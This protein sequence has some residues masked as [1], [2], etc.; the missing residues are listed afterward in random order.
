MI[1]IYIYIYIYK[2]PLQNCNRTYC[3]DKLIQRT[4]FCDRKYKRKRNTMST[5]PTTPDYPLTESDTQNT[6]TKHTMLT[7]GSTCTVVFNGSLASDV[8]YADSLRYAVLILD[9]GGKLIIAPTY[10]DTLEKETREKQNAVLV[11]PPPVSDLPYPSYLRSWTAADLLN[12]VCLTDYFSPCVFTTKPMP[13]GVRGIY[14]EGTRN[15]TPIQFVSANREED[16]D[17]KRFASELDAIFLRNK[18]DKASYCHAYSRQYSTLFERFRKRQ[19]LRYLEVSWGDESVKT[20]REWFPNADRIVRIDPKGNNSF[21]PNTGMV[22]IRGTGT[23]TELIERVTREHGP[24]DIIVDDGT[25]VLCD[26]KCTFEAMFP[27]LNDHGLYIVEDTNVAAAESFFCTV[28]ET[29]RPD[30]LKDHL[31]YFAHRS[32]I[33]SN[34]GIP[35][36]AWRYNGS[37]YTNPD[38][39]MHKTKDAIDA[40][41]GGV[42]FGSG[43]VAVEKRVKA[44]WIS[45]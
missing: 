5:L 32:R 31:T 23:D 44:H 40:S 25:H 12:A 10:N 17:A 45:V 33:L 42:F 26:V 2:M 3:L 14:F 24:F 29:P 15:S 41:I 21:D 39:V 9:E 13:T 43:F 16:G 7:V 34:I 8:Y 36:S 11:S 22:V 19:K 18:S 30:Y 1:Y 27:L 37:Y 6:A 35:N 4:Y 38:L 28:Q 20:I